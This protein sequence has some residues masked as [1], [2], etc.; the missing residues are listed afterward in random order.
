MRVLT[1]PVDTSLQ[2]LDTGSQSYIHKRFESVANLCC[3]LRFEKSTLCYFRVL[4]EVYL[5]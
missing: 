1:G 4:G 5:R 2:V 3:R